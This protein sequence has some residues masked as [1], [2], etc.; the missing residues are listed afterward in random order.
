MGDYDVIEKNDLWSVRAAKVICA[1][2]LGIALFLLFRYLGGLVAVAIASF[3]VASVIAPIA[4][5]ISKKTRISEKLCAFLLVLI[6]FLI[7]GM[8]IA[9]II[10]RLVGECEELLIWLSENRGTVSGTLLRLIEGVE[11]FVHRLPFLGDSEAVNI[12]VENTVSS[13]VN[14][15]IALVG[16]KAGEL[17]ASLLHAT[18]KALMG[19]VVFVLSCFYLS[20]DLYRVRRALLSLMPPSASKKT[21]YICSRLSGALKQYIRAY[22]IIFFI[23][24]CQVF[25]G[26]LILRVRYALIISL[27]IATVD[28]L[29]V[30]GSGA[31]LIPW[32]I[33]S[34]MI[35]NNTLFVGLLL[36]Y[37][38]VTVV[39]QIAEPRIVG[40]RLGIHPLLS[41]L[42][43]FG[44]AC[45]FGVAGALIGP[46]LAVAVKEAVFAYKQKNIDN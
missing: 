6:F 35:G 36:I 43:M 15:G 8:I 32:S 40:E 11:R 3:A 44:G 46:L 34:L 20:M 16:R 30:L 27:A 9:F 19:V 28:I 1:F 13:I 23:T 29:P 18:P 10:I 39:R 33:I 24:F 25:A 41:L 4:K 12:Y 26:L 31:V 22:V 14:D 17:L 42:F 45:A 2:A 37:G 21:E 38:I 5:R 7:L